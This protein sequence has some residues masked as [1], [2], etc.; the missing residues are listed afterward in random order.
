VEYVQGDLDDT[1]ALRRAL[2]GC[3]A[4]H[5]SVRGG[6]TAEQYD[7]V[8]HRGPSPGRW[9]RARRPSLDW[10]APAGSASEECGAWAVP[11]PEGCHSVNPSIVVDE[12]E[13]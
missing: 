5:L 10:S 4:V 11:L 9:P 3:G 8:E 1:D 13:A 2:A 12:A 6:P 7:R